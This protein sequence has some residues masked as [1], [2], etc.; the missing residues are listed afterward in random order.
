MF[1]VVLGR[2]R[3][4]GR[5]ATVFLRHHR[6]F[7]RCQF[8]RFDA[9]FFR[10]RPAAVFEQRAGLR[11]F[12]ALGHSGRADVRP[13]DF[14]SVHPQ[15]RTRFGFAFG[16]LFF[17][18]QQRIQIPNRRGGS[19]SVCGRDSRSLLSVCLNQTDHLAVF[20]FGRHVQ[21]LNLR[22][23]RRG[24]DFQQFARQRDFGVFVFGQNRIGLRRID[25]FGFRIGAAGVFERG[26]NV[27]VHPVQKR[28]TDSLKPADFAGEQQIPKTQFQFFARIERFK[29]VCESELH[30]KT[31]QQK[32]S[33]G[34][35]RLRGRIDRQNAVAFERKQNKRFQIRHQTQMVQQKTD[36][37]LHFAHPR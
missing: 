2:D 23:F 5:G 18:R 30:A 28:R 26:R 37:Q 32:V 13:V 12:H 16:F 22:A 15:P 29:T 19:D 1:G 34:S 8:N 11:N 27:A 17:Q 4:R 9:D 35:H 20:D 24:F 36:E 14:L 6:G 21:H 33:A 3:N 10:T 7:A 31:E 25:D